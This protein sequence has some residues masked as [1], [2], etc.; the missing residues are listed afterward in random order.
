MPPYWA[1]RTVCLPGTYSGRTPA[2]PA[3]IADP[4]AASKAMS[5]PTRLGMPYQFLM[6]RLASTLVLL[7]Y[8]VQADPCPISPS[9][10]ATPR[11][12]R[13]SVGTLGVVP[14]S[15][16]YAWRRILH[17]GNGP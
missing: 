17:A 12:L 1:F 5:R 8:W 4:R 6:P 11:V 9:T 2:P 7:A 16:Q 3:R 15:N 14:S 13:G 10:R